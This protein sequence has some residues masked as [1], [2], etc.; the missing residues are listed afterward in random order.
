MIT[1]AELK[2][3][4]RQRADMT[5]SNFVSDSELTSYLNSAIAEL[6]DIL[7]EAY[8]EDYF[9]TEFEFTTTDEEG[10]TLPDEFYELKRLDIKLDTENW[11]TLQRFN[12][13]QE[14]NLRSSTYVAFGGYV[15]IK[16]RIMG[17]S[18]KLAPLPSP[19]ST[20]RALYVPLPIKLVDD[21][22]T[23][24]DFNYYSEFVIVTAAAKMLNKEESDTAHL[25]A[26]RA[27]QIARIQSKA[28]A[29]DA[30]NS[31]QITDIYATNYDYVGRVR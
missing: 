10:Y 27:Q 7:C 18:I 2:L 16:Y 13:N 9:L 19:G 8:G 25:D 31:E 15:N 12:L 28:G 23:L 5:R 4:A 6:Y 30:A 22:D 26:E 1:L 21:A 24:Q 14:T 3:Q 29:R 20:V 17:N 11:L